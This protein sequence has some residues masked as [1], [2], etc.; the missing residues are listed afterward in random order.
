MKLNQKSFNKIL[1]KNF[2]FEN[3]PTVAIAVSGGPDSMGLLF[4]LNDIMF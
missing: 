1:D 4:L 2:I 3:Y